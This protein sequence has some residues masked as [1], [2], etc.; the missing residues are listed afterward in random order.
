[1]DFDKNTK[2]ENE[3]I[4]VSK[5][6]REVWKP[7]IM[8]MNIVYK[9]KNIILRNICLLKKKQRNYYLKITYNKYLEKVVPLNY[10]EKKEIERILDLWKSN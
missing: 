2:L 4:I 9:N 8:N 1:M 5:Y 3:E 10:E 6:L 7:E